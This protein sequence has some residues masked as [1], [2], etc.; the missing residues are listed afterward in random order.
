MKHEIIF[1]EDFATSKK[2]DKLTL[3]YTLANKLV[4]KEK[5]AE[6]ASKAKKPAAEDVLPPQSKVEK[7]TATKKSKK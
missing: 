2:G 1:I 6:F 5:V 7:P 4:H 3:S